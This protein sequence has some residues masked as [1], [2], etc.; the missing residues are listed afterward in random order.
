M[1]LCT[2][3]ILFQISVQWRPQGNTTNSYSCMW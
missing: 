1:R 2:N 3:G